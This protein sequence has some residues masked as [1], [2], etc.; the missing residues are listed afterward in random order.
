MFE[1]KLRTMLAGSTKT[2]HLLCV[3]CAVLLVLLCVVSY[4]FFSRAR[5]FNA[6]E[7]ESV[8][9][10]LR[11]AVKRVALLGKTGEARTEEKMLPAQFGTACTEVIKSTLND[12]RFDGAGNAVEYTIIESERAVE[13]S[14]SMSGA[15]EQ[16]LRVLKAVNEFVRDKPYIRIDLSRLTR[17][18]AKTRRKEYALAMKVVYEKQ[19]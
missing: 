16:L 3:L 4:G 5:S 8:H 18:V 14:Y 19:D 9:G 15:I 12:K 7:L 6:L 11:A 1:K 13:W 17:T 2:V 10:Q